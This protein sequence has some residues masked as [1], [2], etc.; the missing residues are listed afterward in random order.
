MN[1]DFLG[2]LLKALIITV[3]DAL[4]TAA[5]CLVGWLIVRDLF[6]TYATLVFIPLASF[7]MLAVSQYFGKDGGQGV[8]WAA[9]VAVAAHFI[10]AGGA[11]KKLLFVLLYAAAGLCGFLFGRFASKLAGESAGGDGDGLD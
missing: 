11:P 5:C 1:T 2:K 4:I 8:L 6:G 10:A 3:R 9:V 7:L